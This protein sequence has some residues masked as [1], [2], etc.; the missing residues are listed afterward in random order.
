MDKSNSP[1]ER[2]SHRTKSILDAAARE[3]VSAIPNLGGDFEANISDVSQALASNAPVFDGYRIA[4][5]LEQSHH[6]ECDMAI[7]EELDT[8]SAVVSQLVRNLTAEWVEKNAI[9][10]KLRV[11][12]A[13]SVETYDNSNRRGR[14][15]GEVLVID[16]KHATYTIMIPALGHVREGQ[17]THGIIVP[18]EQ[19]HDLAAPAE[20]FALASG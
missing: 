14:F 7:V 17:G 6:W 3:I 12:E 13:T 10:P 11:G 4:R 20:E 8:A 2:P 16:E 1:F 5:E 9:R 18:Y 19:L 15:D